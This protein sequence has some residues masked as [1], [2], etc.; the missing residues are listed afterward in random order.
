VLRDEEGM[1]GKGKEGGLG[2]IGVV[3]G[4]LTFWFRSSIKCRLL[5]LGEIESLLS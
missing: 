1:E 4:V 2:V 3:E 5:L